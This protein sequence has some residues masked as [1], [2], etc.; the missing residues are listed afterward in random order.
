MI[1]IRFMIAIASVFILSACA[2]DMAMFGNAYLNQKNYDAAISN[3]QAAANMEPGN[4]YYQ[5]MTGRAYHEKGSYKEAIPYFEKAVKLSPS[6]NYYNWLAH[7]YFY[8]GQPTQANEA[9]KKALDLNPADAATK[10][11]ALMLLA[12][13]SESLGQKEA[14]VNAMNRYI[15]LDPNDS[16]GFAGL[17]YFLSSQEKYDDAITA[18][19]RAIELKPDDETAVNNLGYAYGMKEQYDEAFKQFDKAL[20]INPRSQ[21][22]Y[23][24]IGRFNLERR[25]YEGAVSA[26]RKYIEIS[27][28]DHI[29]H[30]TLAV[31]YG[32]MGR[33]AEALE[34]VNKSI[35][36][37]SFSGIGAEV[38]GD[39]EYVVVKSVKKGSP[40]ENAGIKAGDKIV[41]IDGISMKN[42]TVTDVVQKM[43]GEADTTLALGIYRGDAEEP[44]IKNITRGRITDSSSADARGIRSVIQRE[45]GKYEQ[46]YQDAKTASQLNPKSSWAIYSLGITY[47]DKGMY[48]ESVAEFAKLT[49]DSPVAKLFS[50]TATAKKGDLKGAVEKYINIPPSKLSSKSVLTVNARRDFSRLVGSVAKGHLNQASD[51]ESRGKY[52]EAATEISSALLIAEDAA[53]EEALRSRMFSMIRKMPSP[54][55]ITEQARRHVLRGELLIKEKNLG[56]AVTEYKKAVALAPYSAKLYFNLALLYG[57]VKNYEDAI[58]N[59][60]IYLQ[61]A[62]DAPNARAAKDEI[63]KWEL[64]QEKAALK[65]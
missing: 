54:P 12:R 19:K 8:V 26:I 39:K 3:F 55:E 7:A 61:A 16:E 1:I 64:L 36:L 50:A 42:K 30:S 14:A 47:L 32:H 53:Q 57:E 20:A 52:A 41:S 4:A 21:S 18:L 48:D 2:S 35:S 37:T 33:F 44:V 29:A 31:A 46:A 13:S 49:Y 56:E 51:F 38:A 22:A 23:R 28:D 43:R 5:F 9:I 25:N 65:R 62:P 24:N 27:P 11:Q 6:A 63:I 58:S 40:A 17:G 34:A 15:T 59:M 60:K 45:M 10:K